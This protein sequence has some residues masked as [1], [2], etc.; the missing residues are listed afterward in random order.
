MR[1]YM[2]FFWIL[3]VCLRGQPQYNRKQYTAHRFSIPCLHRLCKRA[4]QLAS[5]SRLPWERR[6]TCRWTISNKSRL[7]GLLLAYKC[8]L[9]FTCAHGPIE[10]DGIEG[11]TTPNLVTACVGSASFTYPRRCQDSYILDSHWDYHGRFWHNWAKQTFVAWGAHAHQEHV[12][13]SGKQAAITIQRIQ[14]LCEEEAPGSCW[15]ANEA[16]SDCS[17]TRQGLV[18]N[19]RANSRTYTAVSRHSAIIKGRAFYTSN[20]WGEIPRNTGTEHWRVSKCWACKREIKCHRLCETEVE[21]LHHRQMQAHHRHWII[22]LSRHPLWQNTPYVGKLHR[23]V[24][25]QA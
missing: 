13:R 23:L 20:T 5:Q 19:G 9:G 1:G 7:C 16:P 17:C 15:V 22:S 4:Q 25:D 8:H 21:K 11:V 14:T 24:P 6:G 18:S 10:H 2:V 12:R 3:L